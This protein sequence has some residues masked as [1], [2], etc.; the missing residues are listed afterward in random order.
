MF[1]ALI[2]GINKKKKTHVAYPDLPSARR[3]VP[4]SEEVPIPALPE[5]LDTF[6]ES[7]E[8]Y[9]EM[10]TSTSFMPST[11]KF[12]Q[13]VSFNQAQLN[14]LTRDLGLSKESAQLLGSRLKENNLLSPETTYYWYRSR[15]EEFRKYFSTDEN[16]M[17]VYCVNVND[18]IEALGFP[19]KPDEWRLFIDSS[20]RSLKAVLLHIGNK[21]ESVP[22]AHSIQLT[23]NYETMKI[24][25][26][27]L[28]YNFH[29]WRIC[30]DLKVTNIT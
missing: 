26:D 28:K 29:K 15:D 19:Y 5:N 24:L 30:G 14:D 16:K 10:D 8:E 4:H 13:P 2:S 6:Q 27:A 25:L 18:L 21:V 17:L 22:L 20:T 9:E 7:D 23:E 1:I 3:P 12:N 11:S